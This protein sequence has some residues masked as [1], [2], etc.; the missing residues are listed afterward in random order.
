MQDFVAKRL[1]VKRRDFCWHV[2]AYA[3]GDVYR[4]GLS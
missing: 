2:I 1:K 4:S 3:A